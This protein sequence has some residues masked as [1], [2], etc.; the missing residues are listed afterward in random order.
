MPDNVRD[1][2]IEVIQQEGQMT[3]EE[4]QEYVE[5]LDRTKRYQAE[6]WS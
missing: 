4:A 2:L 3:E 5:N 6:T 1:A